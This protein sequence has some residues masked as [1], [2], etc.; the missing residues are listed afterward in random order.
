MTK[1][2][3]L[4]SAMASMALAMGMEQPKDSYFIDINETTPQQHKEFIEANRPKI[5]KAHG[6]KPFIKD[7]ITVFAL[8]QKNADRKFNKLLKTN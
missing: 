7:G 5:H 1:K 2:G 6:L 3:Q 8:N 4:L